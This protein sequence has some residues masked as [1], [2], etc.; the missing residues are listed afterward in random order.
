MANRRTQKKRERETRLKA[1]K[2]LASLSSVSI[3]MEGAESDGH[4]GTYDRVSRGTTSPSGG[5]SGE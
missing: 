4:G 2:R 1:E 5:A 3:K